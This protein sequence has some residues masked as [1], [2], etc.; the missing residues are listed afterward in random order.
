MYGL[1][2]DVDVPAAAAG[3]NTTIWAGSAEPL[4][5]VCNRGYVVISTDAYNAFTSGSGGG[6]SQFTA[7]EV[8]ALKYQAANPSPFN[9]SIED[10]YLVAGAVLSV[11]IAAWCAKA[12]VM[13]LR[14]DGLSQ[15][16]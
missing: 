16:E 14:S 5:D 3:S 15:S 9:L 13:A 6:V 1:C 8:A 12:L 10:G 11:W 4:G 7:Q 2:L